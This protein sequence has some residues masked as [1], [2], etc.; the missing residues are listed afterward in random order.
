MLTYRSPL[1]VSL[2][3]AALAGG[4]LIGCVP[5]NEEPRLANSAE[6]TPAAEAVQSPHNQGE[7]HAHVAG[8]HGG[9]IV[10]IGA[11]SY[12][13]E[14]VIESNGMIRLLTLG[15]DETRIENVEVQTLTAFVKQS[16]SSDS[17]SIE[18]TASPQEGDDAGKTSQF[19]GQLPDSLIGK[20]LDVTIPNLRINGERFRVGFSTASAPASHEP[21]LSNGAGVT[22]EQ[23]LYLTPGGKY[24][25]ADIAANGKMT[26]SQKFKG[27]ASAHDMN[28]AEGDRICPVTRTKANPEFTWIIDGKPYQFC[29]PPCVSEFVK[30]AKEEPEQLKDPAEYIK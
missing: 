20:M 8:A 6:P 23:E 5:R 26:A 24:T 1:L 7:E 22:K 10:P 21:H 2:S 9:T 25:S 30:L 28:P 11:D 27:I 13:A 29:C 16:G 17:V 19:T 18:L 12:H 4:V 14:V 15:P 3:L